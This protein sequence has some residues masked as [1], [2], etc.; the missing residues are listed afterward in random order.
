MSDQVQMT[1]NLRLTDENI[2]ELKSQIIENCTTEKGVG[3]LLKL[4][5]TDASECLIHGLI[6]PDDIEK[7][8]EKALS[9]DVLH[10]NFILIGFSPF[11]DKDHIYIK[12]V[13]NQYGTT[14]SSNSVH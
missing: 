14:S 10:D 5:E 9:G 13:L 4:T 2:Q 8:I 7:S 11:I 1:S 3:I 6:K 12:D